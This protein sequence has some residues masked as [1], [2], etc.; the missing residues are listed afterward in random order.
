MSGNEVDEILEKGK[1][2]TRKIAKEKYDLMKKRMG[3][4]R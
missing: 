2:K 1:E 4:I 3:V